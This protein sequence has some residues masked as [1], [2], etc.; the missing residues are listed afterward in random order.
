MPP[1]GRHFCLDGGEGVLPARVQPY[2]ITHFFLTAWLRF[3]IY[4]PVTH[5]LRRAVSIPCKLV[6]P[7]IEMPK[8]YSI[9]LRPNVS[10]NAHHLS[11]R[12]PSANL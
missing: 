5:P 7:R 10:F 2:E 8:E 4:Y 3:L 11:K 12:A 9:M 1:Q 6:G